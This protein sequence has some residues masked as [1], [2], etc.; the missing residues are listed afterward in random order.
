MNE[1]YQYDVYISY[2]KADEAWVAAE[3]RP[4]LREAQVNFTDQHQFILGIPVLDEIERSIIESRRTLLVLTQK[5][6][7]DTWGHF[8]AFLSLSYGVES[9]NWSAVPLLAADCPTLPR[10]ITALTSV[11]VA[12]DGGQGW[13]QL[14][15]TLKAPLAPRQFSDLPDFARYG[16]RQADPREQAVTGG[17]RSLIDLMS[18]PEVKAAVRTFGENFR[19][20]RHQ[21]QVLTD[22]K[23]MH[24]ELHQLQRESYQTMFD[25]AK[26]FPDD[27]NAR[28]RLHTCE[29][30]LRFSVETIEEQLK[31]RTFAGYQHSWVRILK[32]ALADLE[33]ANARKD[34]NALDR[35]VWGVNAVL[36]EQPVMLNHRLIEAARDLRLVDLVYALTAIRKHM[37][38]DGLSAGAVSSFEL[39][40]E[41]LSDLYYSL[42][43]LVAE[44]DKWQEIDGHFRRVRGKYTL[45]ELK[46]SRKILT[47]LLKT[48]C[49]GRTDA[50][51]HAFAPEGMRITKAIAAKDIE[52]TKE[53][54]QMLYGF[55]G[56]R[57]IRVDK[58]LKGLCEDLG[59]V[60]D[61]LNLL[62][63]NI[64]D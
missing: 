57:F 42:K 33:R 53:P 62:L 5:Y 6:L 59:R 9:K 63:S 1:Q 7:E 61:S 2:S 24:D 20:A 52:G 26:G 18:V 12:A 45:A 29:L 47:F 46:N 49:A 22:Y 8:G 31:S 58:A 56:D 37:H 28:G 15:T 50:W 14:I 30:D 23:Y 60:G 35:A 39:A 11:N 27:A 48:A 32:T 21:I 4:R 36:G 40:I 17:L 55:A 34:P 64:N 13:Q 16:R 25:A 38:G 10:V 3:L 54:F 43:S 51:A 19:A 41:N 44:H